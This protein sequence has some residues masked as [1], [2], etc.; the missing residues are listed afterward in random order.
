GERPQE[1]ERVLGALPVAVKADE[2]RLRLLPPAR[3]QL[4]HDAA[5]HHG[6]HLQDE[7]QI[8]LPSAGTMMRSWSISRWNSAGAGDCAPAASPLS[9]STCASRR[10]PS[11]PAATAARAIAGTLSRMPTPWLGS[12]TTGRWERFSIT[13]MAEMS[14]VL[15]VAVSKVRMPRSQSTM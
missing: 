2:Q 1:L 6:R 3:R 4:D 5:V 12:A 15:R 11:A 10:R 7:A 13:G 8:D 9:G 14:M